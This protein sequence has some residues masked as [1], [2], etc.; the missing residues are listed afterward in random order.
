VIL[1]HHVG[2]LR[3]P[4]LA[5]ERTWRVPIEPGRGKQGGRRSRRFGHGQKVGQA[6]TT[7]KRAAPLA[8]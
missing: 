7:R 3:R 5:G 4:Q 1:P 6:V 8:G 2:K